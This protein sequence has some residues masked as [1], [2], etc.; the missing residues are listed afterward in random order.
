MSDDVKMDTS[1]LDKL[2]KV[3]KDNMPR[4]RV[5]IIGAKTTRNNVEVAGGKSINI[6]TKGAKPK[7]SFEVSTNAAVGALHEFGTEHMPIRSFLRMPLTDYL[8]KKIEEQGL[9]GKDELKAVMKEGSTTPWLKRLAVLAE[10]TIAEAFATGGFGKWAP[11][12]NPNYK[13]D[14]NR[15]L[16]D[17]RQ[18]RDSISSEV[19]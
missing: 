14:D 6:A 17:T 9:F 1:G 5:G 11:W 18:L 3:L 19:K 8:P 13:N 7:T 2:L 16:V 15:I 12:K 4:V 10:A